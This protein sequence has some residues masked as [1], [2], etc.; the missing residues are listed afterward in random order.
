MKDIN[1]SITSRPSLRFDVNNIT[2]VFSVCLPAPGCQRVHTDPGGQ[3]GMALVLVRY[4]FQYT[5]KDG[6][7]VSIR[8]NESFL[9][10]SRTNEH[11]WRVRRDQHT[12]P[13]YVPAQYVTEL[14]SLPGAPAASGGEEPLKA[15]SSSSF[16]RSA[17]ESRSSAEGS[18]SSPLYA[19]PHSRSR[20]K[21]S[22]GQKVELPPPLGDSDDL[23]L[24]PP[25]PLPVYDTVADPELQELDSFPEPPAHLNPTVESE[26]QTQ[27]AEA[28]CPVEV[29]P[30]EQVSSAAQC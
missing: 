5:A 20:G 25:P 22:T 9:L 21:P 16:T 24:P 12:R 6:R 13:F 29:P 26:L 10:L 3:R 7:L 17:E 30:A 27:T 8:P 11:W 2:L 28:F 19:T 23:E 1:G 14:V 15:P 18:D 4:A